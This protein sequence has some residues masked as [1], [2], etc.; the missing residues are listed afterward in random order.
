[1]AAPIIRIKRSAVPGKKPTVADLPLGELALNTYDAE[2]FIQRN[3]VGIGS[4][5]VRVSAGTS[6]VISCTGSTRNL[7]NI[8]IDAGVF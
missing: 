8:T 3:R 5:I 6:Q 2:L 1:M 4:D 7:E